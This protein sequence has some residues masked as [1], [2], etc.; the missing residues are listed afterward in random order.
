MLDVIIQTAKKQKAFA[1]I[2]NFIPI[3]FRLQSKQTKLISWIKRST[4]NVLECSCILCNRNE[5]GHRP[6]FLMLR[7]AYNSDK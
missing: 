5:L 6:Y 3:S 7:F 2:E 1:V 4:T